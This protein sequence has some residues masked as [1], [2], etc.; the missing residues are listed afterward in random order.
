MFHFL[1]QIKNYFYNFFGLRTPCVQAGLLLLVSVPFS[2]C[3]QVFTP[4]VFQNFSLPPSIERDSI[5]KQAEWQGV[6]LELE[7]LYSQ[8]KISEVVG[9]LAD[10]LPALTPLWSEQGV[11]TTS[12]STET[13]SYALYLWVDGEA[14]TEGLLS[15]LT[16]PNATK[17]T[18]TE[19]DRTASTLEW[20]PVNAKQLFAM[21]DLTAGFSVLVEAFSVSASR[22]T[23]LE[24]LKKKMQ[25]DL[26][27][28]ESNSLSFIRDAKRL[29][30]WVQTIMGQTI[31]LIYQTD[32]DVL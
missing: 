7:R 23:V 12:W 28:E 27:F 24:H 29:S 22:A 8:Q 14:K 31:V 9:Q 16:L 15:K 25:A 10:R 4:Y 18:G 13:A 30:F 20:L 32:R 19:K 26:W 6:G 17:V 1:I 5:I 3:A 2:A 11:L 21:R